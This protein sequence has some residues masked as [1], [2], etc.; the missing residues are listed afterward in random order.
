M[1]DTELKVSFE[2]QLIGLLYAV[3]AILGIIFNFV[4][5]QTFFKERRRSF[6]H[7]QLSIAN[8]IGLLSIAFSGPAALRGRWLLS[9][10][11]CKWFGFQSS[12][13][14]Y[15]QIMFTCVACVESYLIVCHKSNYSNLSGQVFAGISGAIWIY[16]FGLAVAPVLGWNSYVK[17][18]WGTSCGF[19]LTKFI[20]GHSSYLSATLSLTAV[21]VAFSAG[22]VV[23]A[24]RGSKRSFSEFEPLLNDSEL[25]KICGAMLLVAI[26]G[27]I[28]YTFRFIQSLRKIHR[29]LFSTFTTVELSHISVKL[30]S[31]LQPLAYVIF[32][33]YFKELVT[34]RITGVEPGKKNL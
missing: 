28:P 30:G 19:D 34:C 15:A 23:L 24:F 4:T 17:E 13:S 21:F 12:L 10:G 16:S 2:N 31:C 32:S 14:Y 5:L 3:T 7:I 33:T 9:P 20:P 22:C 11:L 8:I 25:V 1:E 18:R 29:P 26:L 27:R 6:F